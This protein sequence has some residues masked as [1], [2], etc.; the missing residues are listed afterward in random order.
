MQ[1]LLYFIAIVA[2]CIAIY[3][4]YHLIKGLPGVIALLI[5][6]L[7]LV[8][9]V[10]TSL[11]NGLETAGNIF[12]AIGIIGTIRKRPANTPLH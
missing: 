11:I 1:V 7:V 10:I 2:A 6:I 4:I 8:L 3:I 12:T 9:G 5:P